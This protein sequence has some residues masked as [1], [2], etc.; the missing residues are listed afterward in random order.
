[1]RAL[2]SKDGDLL[3]YI[4]KNFEFQAETNNTSPKHILVDNHVVA[5]IKSKIKVQLS[6]EHL[7]GFCRTFKKMRNQL[8]FQLTFKTADRQVVI[9]TKIGDDIKINFDK[10]FTFVPIIIPDV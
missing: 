2:T 7:F 8:G 1:M 6:L 9:F 4:D 10:L 5:A 3:S